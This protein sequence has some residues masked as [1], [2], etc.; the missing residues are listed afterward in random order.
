MLLGG[1]NFLAPFD[2]LDTDE[3][4]RNGRPNFFFFYSKNIISSSTCSAS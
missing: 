2:K 4:K 3:V 1:K